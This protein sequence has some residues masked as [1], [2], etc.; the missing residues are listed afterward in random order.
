MVAP[1]MV[2]GHAPATPRPEE[3]LKAPWTTEECVR[4]LAG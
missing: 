3:S 2:D 1:A 4:W